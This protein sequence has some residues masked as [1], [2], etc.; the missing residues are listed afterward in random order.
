MGHFKSGSDCRIQLFASKKWVEK[1]HETK[2]CP[3]VDISFIPP[4]DNVLIILEASPASTSAFLCVEMTP[5][6]WVQADCIGLCLAQ[7][8]QSIFSKLVSNIQRHLMSD[9]NTILDD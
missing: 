9:E 2:A 7:S 6:P 5:P 3:N 1:S 4:F 8:L